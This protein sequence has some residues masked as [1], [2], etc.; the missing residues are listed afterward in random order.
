M[1]RNF[2]RI[3]QNKYLPIFVYGVIVLLFSLFLT[4]LLI[5]MDDGNFLGIFSAPDFTYFGWLK[6][7]YMTVGGRTASEFCV[8]FLL[9]HN[10]ILWKLVN[11]GTIIYLAFF[12][13]KL[14]ESFKGEMPLIKRQIICCSALFLML[15]SCLNPS[16]FWLAGSLTYLWPFSAMTMTVSPLLFYIL[17]E[18]FNWKLLFIAVPA[19]LLGASQ[20]QSAACCTAL[21]VILIIALFVKR[22]PFKIGL[23]LPAVPMLIGDCLL[24]SSPGVAL[25]M[26]AEASSFEKFADMSFVDKLFCGLS[27]FFANSYYLSNFLIILFVALLSVLVFDLA[28]NKLKAKRLLISVNVFSCAVCIVLNYAAAA[29]GGGMAHMTVRTAFNGGEF[30]LGFWLLFCAGC[31]LTAIIAAMLVYLLIKNRRLGL[32]V[33]TCIAAGF[34]AAMALS[35][36]S[37]IFN[38]GQRAYFF[39]NM[40]VITACIVIFSNLKQTKLTNFLYKAAIAYAA[41]TFL[42]DCVAF[43]VAELPIMG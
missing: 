4:R 1:N 19:A 16:V 38:S 15:V 24:L 9:K 3:K 33:A 22:L 43:R 18:K 35:F 31:I 32:I 12:W 34:G 14:S 27:N 17:K 5:K 29:L 36:S 2:E 30:N 8:A 39:T 40:F 25:R 13:T 7:R 26:E 37:S 28:A 11:A 42:V 6:E 41:G 10:V 21:Y 20:E 23:L